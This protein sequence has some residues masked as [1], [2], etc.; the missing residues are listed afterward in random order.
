L[1]F[2]TLKILHLVY[3]KKLIIIQ[4]GSIGI[5]IYFTKMDNFLKYY[6]LNNVGDVMHYNIVRCITTRPLV[7]FY[8]LLQYYSNPKLPMVDKSG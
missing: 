4:C 5:I 6:K 7:G 1:T 2:E 8:Y 3:T